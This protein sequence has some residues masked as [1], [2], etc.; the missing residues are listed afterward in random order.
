M[1]DNIFDIWQV[2]EFCDYNTF[3][4]PNL[5]NRESPNKHNRLCES[6]SAWEVIRGTPDFDG[7]LTPF[8]TR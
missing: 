7:K 1:R 6:K 4:R 3:D 2:V 5:H 8:P